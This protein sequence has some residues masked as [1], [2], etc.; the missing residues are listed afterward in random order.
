M[1]ISITEYYRYPVSS[2]RDR[3]WGLF[4]T[5]AGYQPLPAGTRSPPDR[6]HPDAHYYTW[7]QGRVL[8]EYAIVYVVHGRGEFQSKPTSRRDLAA[9][10]AF[11]LFPG[12]WHRYRPIK[13]IGWATY[14]VHFQGE[15]ADRLHNRGLI[16]PEE[17]VL[18]IGTNEEVVHSFTR[19]LDRLRCEPVGFSQMIAADVLEILA[20]VLGAAR[21][22][23]DNLTERDIVN[24]AKLRLER[25][26]DRLPSIEE[27]PD[28]LGLSR[29]RFF[30]LFK[31]Q[32][33]LSPYQY[34]LQLKIRRAGRMLSNSDMPVK[35]IAGLL[36]FQSAYHFSRLFKRKT[37]FSPRDFRN[38]RSG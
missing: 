21:A 31:Q 38:R 29:A 15:N 30:R 8:N 37:G 20:A 7:Q 14:W 25:E 35:E 34:H 11:L 36:N 1:P 9:G 4:V 27:L 6:P 10:D 2:P 5:G 18:R 16:R 12:V 17:A 24:R 13:E 22:D 28:E 26:D 33:G 3:L 23:R 19:L 32:T